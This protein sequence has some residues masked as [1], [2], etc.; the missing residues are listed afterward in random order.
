MFSIIANHLKNL[1]IWSSY[2]LLV[3]NILPLNYHID[4][5][6]KVF[7]FD[8]IIFTM[9]PELNCDFQVAIIVKGLIEGFVL[10]YFKEELKIIP[11]I[12]GLKH[13]IQINYYHTG[14]LKGFITYDKDQQIRS[15]KYYKNGQI[16]EEADMII[17]K[18]IRYF[19]N[20]NVHIENFYKNGLKDGK[21]IVYY[22]TGEIDR[23]YNYRKGR[24]YGKQ[25]HYR[26]NGKMYLKL[27]Y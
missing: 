18:C 23:I 3:D 27:K 7:L 10:Q 21:E 24:S 9:G 6:T 1:N 5:I 2:S 14:E 11:H 4:Q 12:N 20:G 22:I 16:E 17:G 8:N 19:C 15:V 26:K 25:Y 13:G